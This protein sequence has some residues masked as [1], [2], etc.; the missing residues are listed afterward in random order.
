[1]FFIEY[2]YELKGLPA[3]YSF[4]LIIFIIII[5]L[6]LL[7]LLLLLFLRVKTMFN[8]RCL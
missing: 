2:K 5:I 1:M 7:L 6:L 4:F 3:F 8:N